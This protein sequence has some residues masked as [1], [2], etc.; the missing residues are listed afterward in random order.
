MIMAKTIPR[1]SALSI[2]PPAALGGSVLD[3]SCHWMVLAGNGFC[4]HQYWGR[5]SVHHAGNLRFGDDWLPLGRSIHWRLLF[6]SWKR[7]LVFPIDSQRCKIG[8]QSRNKGQSYKILGGLMLGLMA[9]VAGIKVSLSFQWPSW[10]LLVLLLE[11]LACQMRCFRR[12]NI[13]FQNLPILRG[14]KEAGRQDAFVVG[15]EFNYTQ[16]VPSPNRQMPL[17]PAS[18]SSMLPS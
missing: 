15:T 12:C 1:T 18:T 2:R 8:R 14:R 9:F 17:A 4:A 3:C 13:Q 11:D 5:P 7:M 6:F 16:W 10:W